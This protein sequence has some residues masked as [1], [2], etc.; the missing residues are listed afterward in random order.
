MSSST[1]LSLPLGG[2]TLYV[3][4]LHPDVTDV[5]LFHLFSKVSVMVIEH[6]MVSRLKSDNHNGLRH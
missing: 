5:E 2:L 1:R 3:G 6:A 4:D